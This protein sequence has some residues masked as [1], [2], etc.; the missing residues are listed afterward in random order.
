MGD[1]VIFNVKFNSLVT[2]Y[3]NNPLY[4]EKI[5][6]EK[7][8]E[9]IIKITLSWIDSIKFK[10]KI[11]KREP[12]IVDAILF[13]EYKK[14]IVFSDS[15][16]EV[17]YFVIKISQY[18]KFEVSEILL[19]EK[20]FNNCLLKRMSDVKIIALNIKNKY[21][22]EKIINILD[23]YKKEKINEIINDKN[24]Q[25]I[26]LTI[27]LKR[28]LNFFLDKRSIISTPDNLKGKETIELYEELIKIYDKIYI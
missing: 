11:V 12:R 16:S 28:N 20:I 23:E 25:I 2:T 4:F 17:N 8:E 27:G 3:K 5:Q 7:I 1:A 6:T 24:V 19:F 10:D 21:G 22:E 13:E 26:S 18:L 9:G 14:L 15:E